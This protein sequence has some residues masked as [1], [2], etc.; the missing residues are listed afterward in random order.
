[1]MPAGKYLGEEFYRA[2]GVPAV[3]AELIE[4]GKIHESAK[5]V[6]GKT[7]GENY[8][9]KLSWDREVIKPYGDPLVEDA[10]FVVLH[11]NLFDSAIMKTSVISKA[12]RERY[13][14][15]AG[16]LDAFEGKAV[17]FDGR[18]DYT[19]RIDDPSLEID[20]NTL[21]F[22]R[23]A[24]PIGHPGAAE[25]VNM[26]PPAALIK[27]GITSLP[28][29][30]DG[31]QSGTSGSP[32]ILN[33]SPEAASG[34]GLAILKTGDRV[35]IDLRKGEANILI[36]DGELAERRMELQKR[37]GYQYPPSQ[38]PWQEIQRAM[39][40][41]LAE[42]MVPKP[43]VKYQRVAQTMGTPRDSH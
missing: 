9:G 41:Q 42:G 5:T 12:F 3:V 26:Q 14:S 11:G 16:D 35:R 30:G 1:M 40:E 28:C 34:G 22:M 7:I 43:A 2:G 31:R 8:R 24:G 25:V 13:L 10:G 37:G 39:V 18:E 4:A 21:L 33:A 19:N 36:S 20:E 27:R 23:G 17:V 38:T 6:N 32:S 29:I 15:K